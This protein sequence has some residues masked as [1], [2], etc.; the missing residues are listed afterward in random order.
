MFLAFE[1]SA[2]ADGI[3]EAETTRLQLYREKHF[4]FN[5]RYFHQNLKEG[6]RINLSY[7]W[8]KLAPRGAGLVGKLRRLRRTLPGMLLHINASKHAWFQDGR[9]CDLYYVLIAIMDDVTSEVYDAQWVEEEGTRPAGGVFG[10]VKP[11]VCSGG[12]QRKRVRPHAPEGF[13]LDFLAPAG[14][15]CERR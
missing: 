5:V 12:G 8:V 4:D 11:R 9:H 10:G 6:H 2:H 3:L 14:T 15:C 13:G 1:M 7:A